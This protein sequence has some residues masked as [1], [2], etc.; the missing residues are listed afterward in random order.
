VTTTEEGL[1]ELASVYWRPRVTDR[2]LKYAGWGWTAWM[3]AHTIPFITAAVVLGLLKPVTIPV[4][5][6]LLAHAWLIPELYASKGANVMRKRALPEP[7]ADQVAEALLESLL[8]SEATS[9][10]ERTGA[11]MQSGTLGVWLVGEGGALLIRPGGRRVNCYCV[12]ATGDD[13]PSAD[14]TSHLLLGLRSDEVGFATLSNLA[15]SGAPW[16]VRRRLERPMR[17]ALAAAVEAARRPIGADDGV[18]ASNNLTRREHHD[19][20]PR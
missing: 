16:R 15:F 8:C 10:F 18:G 5:V 19:R 12:R 7:L 3:C 6:I 20:A 4:G 17:P 13:L 11:V 9:L 2:S 14:R 1:P